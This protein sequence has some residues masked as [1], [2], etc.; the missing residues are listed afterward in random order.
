MSVTGKR[1]VGI[2]TILLHDAEGGL[3]TIELKNGCTYRGILDESED[4]MNCTM[5][6]CLLFIVNCSIVNLLYLKQDCV[7]VSPDGKES[8]IEV[9]YI[10]GSQIT[11]LILPDTL[12]RAPFFNRIKMWRKFRGHAIYGANTAMIEAMGGRGGGRGGRGGGRGVFPSRGG[13]RG[14]GRF[15]VGGGR[16]GDGGRGGGSF[17][18]PYGSGGGYQSSGGYNNGS[19]GGGYQQQDPRGGYGGPPTSSYR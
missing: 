10:R 9:A 14:G 18:T 16:F 15:E 7:K 3:I 17:P 1:G 2:P 12:K 13:G 19:S 6:V 4:N 8:N 5:K 11:F